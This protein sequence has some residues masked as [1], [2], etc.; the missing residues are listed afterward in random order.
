MKCKNA[1]SVQ[2]FETLRDEI[3]TGRY[4][5]ARMFPSEV[6]LSRR[7]GVSRSMM[8]IVVGELEK[9]GLVS[10]RQ[11]RGTFVTGRGTSR[12]IGLIVP[13]IA[14]SE[15]FPPIVSEI[16]RL[17]GEA[18]YA[19]QF[20][21]VSETEAESRLAKIR[22]VAADMLAAGVAGVIYH[23]LE[24]AAA[25]VRANAEIVD[26]FDRAGVQVVLLDRPVKPLPG[27]K[28]HDVVGIDNFKAGGAI[29]E[30]LC[31]V[32]AKRICY[33]A[34]KGL[35]PLGDRYEGVRAVISREAHRCVDVLLPDT[36]SPR[37]MAAELRRLK[38]EAVVCANDAIAARFRQTLEK[39]GLRVPEDIL[40]AG[41]DDMSIASLMTPPLTTVHQPCA[42]IAGVA[43]RRLLERIANP[44]LPVVAFCLS[45][46]VVVR[47]STCPESTP[48]QSKRRKS[49]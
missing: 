48:S 18:G 15:F 29:A 30:H 25:S 27:G 23:P 22:Q 16:S 9:Q 3:L 34:R 14:Y 17:S 19:L 44:S 42:E 1:R 33:L 28:D 45:A 24:F 7:F 10:R 2:I 36:D 39:I 12:K 43:F 21:D 5:S 11:G 38:P 32:G 20:A 46:P 47:A 13:G 4:M 40:L 31:A 41:F 6:A 37:R 26:A 49:K 35:A 8:T